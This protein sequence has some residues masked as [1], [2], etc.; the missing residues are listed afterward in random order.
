MRDEKIDAVLSDGNTQSSP[1]DEMC[2]ARQEF[3]RAWNKW[4]QT[5]PGAEDVELERDGHLKAF[6][7]I[8][9]IVRGP[10]APRPSPVLDWVFH[11]MFYGDAKLTLLAL[12]YQA[13]HP[14]TTSVVPTVDMAQLERWSGMQSH[15]IRAYIKFMI[16]L[17]VVHKFGYGVVFGGGYRV[18]FSDDVLGDEA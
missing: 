3:H 7:D 12:S 17:G 2:R 9:Q 11:S 10:T 13:T 6:A 15:R 4:L 8:E 18:S 1:F 16:E 5:V 14:A